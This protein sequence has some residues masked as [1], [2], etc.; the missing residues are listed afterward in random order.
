MS[1]ND[2]ENAKWYNVPRSEYD[3]ETE[4]DEEEETG[5]VY[6]DETPVSEVSDEFRKRVLALK[7]SLYDN[8]VLAPEMGS[9]DA[10]SN[11]VL[12][13][14]VHKINKVYRLSLG[15][16]KGLIAKESTL[17]KF[18]VA[19]RDKLQWVLRWIADFFPKN[20]VAKTI[21]YEDFL[22][23]SFHVYPFDQN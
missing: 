17:A 16:Q 18:P 19:T 5:N 12:D 1:A 23:N 21:P 22:R 6:R 3:E 8:T 9:A 20:G 2:E 7:H 11:I 15:A 14:Y 10:Q 13:N 4:S